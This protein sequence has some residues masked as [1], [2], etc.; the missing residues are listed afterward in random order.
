[1]AINLRF[2]AQG[3]SRWLLRTDGQLIVEQQT[4]LDGAPDYSSG[5]ATPAFSAKQGH[6]NR[7]PGASQEPHGSVLNGNP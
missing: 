5:L 7:P 4:E 1:V 6:H 2:S 3:A